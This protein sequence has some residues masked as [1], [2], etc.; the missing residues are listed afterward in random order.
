[1]TDDE[2][3]KHEGMMDDEIPKHEGMMNANSG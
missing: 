3:P 1:M 2:I